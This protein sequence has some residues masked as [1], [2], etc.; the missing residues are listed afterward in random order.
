MPRFVDNM[1][2]TSAKVI[3]LLRAILSLNEVKGKNLRFF[4]RFHFAPLRASAQNVEN[5]PMA[6]DVNRVFQRS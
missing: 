5:P 3:T 2:E 4:G 1:D 6:G